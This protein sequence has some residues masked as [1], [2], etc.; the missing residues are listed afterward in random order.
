MDLQV[1]SDI[2]FLFVSC[3]FKWVLEELQMKVAE[4]LPRKY[5]DVLNY[6][7]MLCRLTD[8][9]FTYQSKWV[10]SENQQTGFLIFVY[11]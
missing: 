3:V 1:K 2:H 5:T 11:M 8:R 10:D 4:L 9:R 6:N 7:R